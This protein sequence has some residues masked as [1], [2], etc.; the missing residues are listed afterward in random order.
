VF[1]YVVDPAFDVRTDVLTTMV[2]RLDGD[3]GKVVHIPLFPTL[4]TFAAA[5]VNWGLPLTAFFAIVIDKTLK[6]RAFD[7]R[8]LVAGVAGPDPDCVVRDPEQPH[9]DPYLLRGPQR[10]R[11]DRCGGR[12]RADRGKGDAR[13]SG[14]SGPVDF[15]AT[16]G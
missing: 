7:R 9:P 10:R 15:H 16:S 2:F 8:V 11:G 3:Y 14:V 13:G 12:R 4:K 6:H 5:I 1:A